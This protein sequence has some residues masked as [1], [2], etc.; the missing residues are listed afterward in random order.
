MVGPVTVPECRLNTEQS[1]ESLQ[2]QSIGRS[3]YAFIQT[4]KLHR[5]EKQWH[6]Q[7]TSASDSLTAQ[8]NKFVGWIYLQEISSGSIS[9]ASEEWY[10]LQVSHTLSVRHISSTIDSP[11]TTFVPNV[12]RYLSLFPPVIFMTDTKTQQCVMHFGLWPI[13]CILAALYW[14][15][16]VVWIRYQ[17]LVHLSIIQTRFNNCLGYFRQNWESEVILTTTIAAVVA[18]YK[19]MRSGRYITS[20]T[21][22]PRPHDVSF[23]T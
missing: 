20:M 10:R 3:T 14:N 13:H 4:W 5:C 6:K 22:Q 2:I 9:L 19:R 18:R 11:L 7:F 16:A 12:T 8:L 1:V 17:L 21:D 15:D 23:A